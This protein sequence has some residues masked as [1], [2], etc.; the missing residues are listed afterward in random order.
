MRFIFEVFGLFYFEDFSDICHESAIYFYL[1]FLIIFSSLILNSLYYLIVDSSVYNRIFYFALLVL[2]NIF[3]NSIISFFIIYISIQKQGFVFGNLP[4]FT[5][6]SISG[7]YAGFFVFLSSLFFKIFSKN[8][9]RI[10]F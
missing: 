2:T 7:F 6:S 10:P 4:F 9:Y 3:I 8:T 5:L 1:F